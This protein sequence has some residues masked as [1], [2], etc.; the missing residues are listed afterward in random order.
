MDDFEIIENEDGSTDISMEL[1]DREKDALMS[2]GFH[3]LLIEDIYQVSMYEIMDILK[4]VKG[5][6]DV[7]KDSGSEQEGSDPTA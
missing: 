2:K 3:Y 1:S 6:Q 7:V 4:E 5:T